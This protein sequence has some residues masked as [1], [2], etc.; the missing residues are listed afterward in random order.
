MRNFGGEDHLRLRHQLQERGNGPDGNTELFRAAT[1]SGGI[2]LSILLR[3]N[4]LPELRKGKSVLQCMPLFPKIFEDIQYILFQCF[5][6][7]K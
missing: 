3:I 5:H 6:K 7:L 4:D 2:W 1:V